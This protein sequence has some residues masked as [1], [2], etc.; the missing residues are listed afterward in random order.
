MDYWQEDILKTIHK[1]M[2]NEYKGMIDATI[3][4][5]HSDFEEKMTKLGKLKDKTLETYQH[6]ICD[7]I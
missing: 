6:I 2:L 4:S 3:E 7:F 5:R 1:D